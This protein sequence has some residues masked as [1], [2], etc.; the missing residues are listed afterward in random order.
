MPTV[1]RLLVEQVLAKLD[2]APSDAHSRALALRALAWA[3]TAVSLRENAYRKRV[4]FTSTGTRGFYPTSEIA[5]DLIRVLAVYDSER[6][7]TSRRYIDLIRYEP[8]W[9][10]RRGTSH[11][12]WAQPALDLFVLWPLVPLPVSLSITYLARPAELV[13][14]SQELSIASTHDRA[15]VDLAWGLLALRA[16]RY[17]STEAAS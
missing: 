10:H 9:P 7:L 15:V 2:D 5:E 16:R 17:P 3:E 13:Q 12:A 1:A 8:G 4:N 11:Q 14:E 6:T